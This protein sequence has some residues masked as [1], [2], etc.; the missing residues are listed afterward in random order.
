MIAA[1]LT[2]FAASPCMRVAL[3]YCA[4]VLA[5]ILSTAPRK[6]ATGAPQNPASAATRDEA[7]GMPGASSLSIF[8]EGQS[9]RLRAR[10]WAR[11]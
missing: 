7:P 10:L 5:V 11:R 4:V 6:S 8:S 1:L 2:D 9:G 3:R